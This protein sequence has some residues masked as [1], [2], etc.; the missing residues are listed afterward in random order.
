MFT[1]RLPRLAASSWVTENIPAGASISRQVWDDA[2]PIRSA[3]LSERSYALV[4]FDLFRSDSSIDQESGLAKPE[5]LLAQLDEVDYIIES[6]NR[7]YDS[8]PRMPAEYPSTVAYYEALFNEQLGFSKIA[9]FENKPS[10]LG[11]DFPSWGSEETFSVYDHP[12]VTIWEKSDDWDVEKARRILNPFAAAN[13]PN[14]LPR[15]GTSNALLLEPSQ[16][17]SMQS[18]DTF[19]ERFSSGIFAGSF[20]SLIHI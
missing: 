13:A 2:V 4:E 1:K 19:D 3:D 7:I 11:F 14:L 20:L 6:S 9:S 17:R 10:L 8:I 5:V 12:A 15:E 16:Y 18:G